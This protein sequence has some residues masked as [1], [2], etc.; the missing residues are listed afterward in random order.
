MSKLYIIG[1][2]VKSEKKCLSLCYTYN[3]KSNERNKIAD[4]N[5]A[6]FCSACVVFEGKIVVTGGFSFSDNCHLKSVELCDNYENKWS[7][8]PDMNEKR[9][10]H[11]AVSMGN[12]LFVIGGYKISSCEVFDSCSRKFT[13][14][15]SEMK[16]LDLERSYFKA[17][18]I[19]SN[20]VVFHHSKSYKSVVYMY[21]VNESKWSMADCSYTKNYFVQSLVKYYI[22]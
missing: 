18:C 14:I 19:G 22:Q 1:G 12:K 4:L 2:W 13:T 8:L 5:L 11:A 10:C 9:W 17:F 7:H 3:I 15:T 16:L 21:D 20:I 6:R